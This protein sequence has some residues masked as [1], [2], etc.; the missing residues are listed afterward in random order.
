[1]ERGAQC[2]G[3]TDHDASRGDP[4]PVSQI[5]PA[6]AVE[7]GQIE[8]GAGKLAEHRRRPGWWPGDGHCGDD[9]RLLVP[10]LPVE[11][12][13]GSGV[14]DPVVPGDRG[15]ERQQ[16]GDHV[17]EPAPGEVPADRCPIAQQ[18]GSHLGEHSGDDAVADGG[19][20]GIL[21]HRGQGGGGTDP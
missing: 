18:R 7:D 5:D 20:P 13:Q 14:V 1:M 11:G 2:R 6:G 4:R 12:G 16:H 3:L 15:V 19:D 9:D 8:Y 10:A 17:G 21:Q